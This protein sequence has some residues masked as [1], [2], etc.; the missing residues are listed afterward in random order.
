MAKKYKVIVDKEKC[1]G[2]GTCVATAS[3]TFKLDTNN[4]A[5]VI[6]GKNDDDE[7]ILKAAESCPVSAI[8]IKDK[9][10]KKVYPKDK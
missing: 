5:D 10:G 4:K 3:K 2:C 6:K 1:I 9:E 7:V 8:E